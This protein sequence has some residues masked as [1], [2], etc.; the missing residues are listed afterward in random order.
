MDGLIYQLSYIGSV[1]FS[2]LVVFFEN[3][4]FPCGHLHYL[5][6]CIDSIL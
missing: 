1:R 6:A 5:L 3:V 4:S 2:G